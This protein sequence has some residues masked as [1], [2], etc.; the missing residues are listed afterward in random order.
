MS[1]PDYPGPSR[2]P[3][4]SI[5]P[6]AVIVLA[7]VVGVQALY[8]RATG[9]R[10]AVPATAYVSRPIAPSGDLA[11]DERST[12]ALF[13]QASRSVVY[14]TTAAVGRDFNLNTLEV[15]R[16]TGTGFVWDEYGH[17]V[18]NFH[19]VD[20]AN[21]WRVTLGDQSKWDAQI[22]GKA[23]D[24]DLAVLRIQAPGETLQPLLI[25]ASGDLEVGQKVFA[26]GN[27]FGLDQ[28]LTT[29]IIS[30]LGR[31]IQAKT[32]R[33]IDGMIQTD[34]AINPGNSGGPLLDSR[35]RL[36]GVNT[37]I[38][39]PTE[40]SVGIGFAIPVDTVQ[41]TVPQLL[42]FGKIIRPGLSVTFAPDQVMQRIGLSGVL[43]IRVQRD[44]AAAQAGIRPTRRSPD[45]DVLLGDVIVAV[46][47]KPVKVVED[48]QSILDDCEIGQH[49]KLTI[50]RGIGTRAEETLE[51]PVVLQAVD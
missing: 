16:G 2:S 10:Q 44:G 18:T 14:I 8:H 33:T 49:V 31:Q 39:S 7:L 5:W 48:L 21:R 47:G 26:I 24:R 19:V 27:P 41:R 17:I 3:V 46:D 9:S 35:G 43:I 37:A 25:G 28:T 34:A 20:G 15:Q 29:G 11:E 36:I 4:A 45:G 32:G 12:I 50:I 22:V 30:G 23:P 38:I 6:L 51:V 1:A 40:A 42:Q 13:K